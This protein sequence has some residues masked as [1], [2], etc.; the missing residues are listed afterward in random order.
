VYIEKVLQYEYKTLNEEFVTVTLGITA[1]QL[2]EYDG[3][4]TVEKYRSM[5][6]AQLNEKRAEEAYY[7]A[8]D[9]MWEYLKKNIEIKKL[10]EKEIRRIYDNYYYGYQAQFTANY[11]SVYSSVDAYI[12]NV[13]GIPDTADWRAVLTA[14]VKDEVKEKLIFYTI[15]RQENL[16]PVGEEFD[17][18]YRAELERDFAYYGKTRDNYE[19]EAEYEAALA[20]YEKQ[21]IEYYGVAFYNESVYYNYASRKILDFANV[22][23]T[24][25]Q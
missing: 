24:A 7:I 1:E 16:T 13:L 19:T 12:C 22:I 11:T 21:V 5:I 14:K 23:N 25:K 15:M 18:V 6:R 2:S 17:A 4:D 3:A 20:S 9:A 8:E 10:P